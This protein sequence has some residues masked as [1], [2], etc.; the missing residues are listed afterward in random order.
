[1][2]KLLL[3]SILCVR[4]SLA[5][6][7]MNTHASGG[8]FH[9][10][11]DQEPI[12]SLDGQWRFHPGDDA[13]WSSQ[14][15]DDSKWT[16]I[17]T[18]KSWDKQGYPAMNGF[19]W[20]RAKLEI[21]EGV[22][23]LS[24][25]VPYVL[26][27]YQVF[28]NGKL[29]GGVGAMPPQ[30]RPVGQF[31]EYAVYRLPD[32]APQSQS[33]V[34]AF[35]VWHS[36]LWEDLIGGGI[37]QGVRV[38]DTPL[39]EQRRE[40]H[41]IESLWSNGALFSLVLIEFLAACASFGFY[42]I[43]RNEREYLWFTIAELLNSFMSMAT[44]NRPLLLI[45]V[46]LHDLILNVLS[47]AS[48]FALLCFFRI[49]LG[50]K[51]NWLF[52]AM[53]ATTAANALLAVVEYAPQ[54]LGMQR[55][56]ISIPVMNGMG[57]A[58][59]VIP[60]FWV[61]GLLLR[62]TVQ[63][64]FDARLLLA[65]VLLQQSAQLGD[66]LNWFFVFI[67]RRVPSAFNTFYSLSKWPF[68]I[69]VPNVCDFLFLAGMLAIFVHRF[70]RTSRMEDA[71]QRELEAARAVQQVLVPSATPRISGF[72]IESLYLPAG[73]VGGDFYQIVATQNGGALIVIGDVSGKGMPAAM[74]VSLLVG[75]VR[76]LAHYT[77]S[78]GEILAAMNQRML[79]RSS[80]GFTTCL[81]MR[82]DPDGTVTAANAGHLAPYLNGVELK[83]ENGLP[84]GLAADTQY[85]ES[86]FMLAAPARLTLLTDGVVE[87]R[88][89]GGELFGFERTAAVSCRSADQIAKT[90][91]LF[92][93][94]DDITVLT[95]T[96]VSAEALH[97]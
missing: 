71:H 92:G 37:Y 29:L 3:L 33:I 36:P 93:Q 69:S 20:Y 21:P 32:P 56:F 35:R 34:L 85:V 30:K 39:I 90:A 16:L 67:V 74:T 8:T 31:R 44:A 83:L 72:D 81:V 27:S 61:V 86:A 1:M 52:T 17:E 96:L 89:H 51:R 63:G 14:G 6:Q 15:F 59:D 28:A 55:G 2:R 11:Q 49:L 23:D 18:G 22:N 25:L 13:L 75:T 24:L 80:G 50:G 88:N 54:F 47:A 64:R 57:A 79:S 60:S 9:F 42:L 77:Q 68:P 10:E 82:V 65:P 95:L 94:E 38:G 76:T 53:L 78:P 41:R 97:A 45:D 84:L 5:A 7:S 91:E 62:R 66:H 12:A 73:Q 46:R 87:A 58:L 40:S 19:A 48:V 70:L 4:V 26:T 43:H